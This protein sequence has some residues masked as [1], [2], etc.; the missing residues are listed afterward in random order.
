MKKNIPYPGL[1]IIACCLY[2]SAQAQTPDSAYLNLGRIELRKEFTQ[3]YS[4]KPEYLEKMPFANL[5]EALNSWLYGNFTN[6]ATIVYIVDGNIAPDVNAY[7]IY[8]IAEITLVQNA[9]IQLNGATGQA[10]LVLIKTKRNKPGKSGLGVAGQSFLVNNSLKGQPGGPSDV[11]LY[12]QYNISAYQNTKNIQYG[13]SVNFM[14]DVLPNTKADSTQTLTPYNI[15]RFR[16]N[17]YLNAQL[18]S[19]NE[20]SANINYTPQTSG[21]SQYTPGPTY[22]DGVS[23]HFNQTQKLFTT[24]ARLHSR[25]SKVFSNDLTVGY[26]AENSKGSLSA[27]QTVLPYGYTTLDTISTTA[28]FYAKASTV[29]IDEHFRYNQQ[30]GN[31][32]IEPALDLRY[33]NTKDT[34]SQF[35]KIDFGSGGLQSATYSTNSSGKIYLLTPSLT[36]GYKNIFGLQG[37]VLT[38]LNSLHGAP[39]KS[40][41]PFVS[42]SFDI[43]KAANGSSASSLKLFGS[44]AKSRD[45]SDPSYP[46]S[47]FTISPAQKNDAI[48]LVNYTFYPA[49]PYSYVNSINLS[50]WIAETGITF[51][52]KGQRFFASYNYERRAFNTSVV[53]TGPTGNNGSLNEQYGEGVVSSTH[54]LAVNAKIMAEK[55]FDWFS[56]ITAAILSVNN[57]KATYV[58]NEYV[59]GDYNTAG[60]SLTGGWVNRARYKNLSFG[61]DFMYHVNQQVFV[62]NPA[63][64]TPIQ[65]K[66]NSLLLQNVYVGYKIKTTELYIAARNLFE[67]SKGDIINGNRYY[68]LGFKSAIF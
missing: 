43:L 19:N 30:V 40:N 64:S 41:Y 6:T 25:L 21:G 48:V 11:N 65:Q 17:S 46:L 60:P 67:N 12:H 16:V 29:F 45:F 58:A 1:C 27:I 63:Y 56:G 34:A 8:D 38:I 39:I 44:Y 57:V 54:R 26:D 15:S 31:W 52:T 10:Q 66:A 20:L 50:P 7:S 42:G 36:L 24:W 4:I 23:Q 51:T 37:G 68:G 3:T 55:D 62:M 18:G 13:A 9:A 14:R 59:T 33:S 61:L 5:T 35:E 32:L 53:I 49:P 47:D 22:G 2:F 28:N